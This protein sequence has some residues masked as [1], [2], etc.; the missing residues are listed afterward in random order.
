VKTADLDTPALTVDLDVLEKNIR[1]QAESCRRCDIPLRVH[2][3][4]HKIPEIAQMQLEAGAI[5]IACQKLGEA[6]VMVGA[7]VRDILI[8]YNIVG[9]AKLDRLG[10]LCARAD[11][12]VAVDSE[13]TARGIS[14]HL[15]PR[16][17]RVGVLVELDTGGKRCGVQSPEAACTLGGAVAGMPGLELKGVMTYPSHERARPFIDGARERFQKAGLPIHVVSGGGT[18]SEVVSKSIGCTEARIGSYV[19][20][21]LRRINRS[22]NPPNPG[23]CAERMLVTVVS[24][25][26]PGRI[27]IDGGKK[28]FTNDR[29]TPYGLIVESPESLIYA[30]S[31]EHGH[32][33]VSAS[34][35]QFAV[36][37]RLSV[38]PQH[39]G[40]TT[41]LHDQVYAV[42]NGAVEAVWQV[43]GRGKV[44]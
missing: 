20:E 8:P 25:P 30:M 29:D 41:N 42:R 16:A 9:A 28:T 19:F 24:T 35:R 40:M 22:S 43:A 32:V 34:R 15:G 18:G 11:I 44:A 5:G 13:V 3:K 26:A 2:T 1:L 10:T 36:G 14:D 6:E 21:G 27:I 38:I 33:D 39:Q 31:V 4:T 17:G 7:G 37:D 23:T 12:T